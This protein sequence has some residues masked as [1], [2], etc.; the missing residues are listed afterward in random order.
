MSDLG[1]EPDI[2]WSLV[3]GDP[4]LD[5]N[6]LTLHPR[7]LRQHFSVYPYQAG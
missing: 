1:L 4:N 2:H 5:D 7:L 6:Y 3:A